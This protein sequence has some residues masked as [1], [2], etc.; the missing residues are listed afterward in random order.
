M[1]YD[2]LVS[3]TTSFLLRPNDVL[4]NDVYFYAIAKLTS[5]TLR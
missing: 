1:G 2:E 3:T 4:N 5:R